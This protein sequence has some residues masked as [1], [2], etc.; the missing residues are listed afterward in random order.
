MMGR[1]G[2]PDPQIKQE[3]FIFVDIAPLPQNKPFLNYKA[4][5]YRL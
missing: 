2:Y 1:D 5:I 3:N 4:P